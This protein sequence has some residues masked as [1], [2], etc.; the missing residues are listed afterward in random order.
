M[1]V[2]LQDILDTAAAERVGRQSDASGNFLAMLD[3]QFG[4]VYGKIDPVEAAA[5]RQIQHREAPIE[6]NRPGG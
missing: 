2:N 5:M 3:R 4:R 1:A 6:T